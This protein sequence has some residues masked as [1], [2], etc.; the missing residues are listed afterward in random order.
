MFFL[1]NLIGKRKR[2]LLH[3][4]NLSHPE[5]PK[6]CVDSSPKVYHLLFVYLFLPSQI[7]KADILIQQIFRV[8]SDFRPCSR[9]LYSTGKDKIYK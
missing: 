7:M 5:L 4:L 6:N 2:N 9:N 1:S 3:E 8:L